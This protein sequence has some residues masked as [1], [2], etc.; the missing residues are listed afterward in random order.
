M[1]IRRA[2]FRA[3][4]LSAFKINHL[5]IILAEVFP[6]VPRSI[7]P[8]VPEPQTIGELA[9]M[10]KLDPGLVRDRL[11]QV[12]ALCASVELDMAQIRALLVSQPEA[13]IYDVEDP[14]NGE[15]WHYSL[16]VSRLFPEHSISQF[17]TDDLTNFR[18]QV[19]GS[20]R[21][22]TICSNGARSLS[23]ALQLRSE[24]YINAYTLSGGVTMQ[25]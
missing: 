4:S 12:E 7:F 14:T 16:K 2:N 23:A 6:L 11:L 9:C 10:T 18:R 21:V 3:Q 19:P 25:E 24:N 5:D 22:I 17:L 20:V 15:D 8:E 13:V 1:N